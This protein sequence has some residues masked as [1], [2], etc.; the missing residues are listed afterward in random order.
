MQTSSFLKKVIDSYT[1][2]APIT[3]VVATDVATEREIADYGDLVGDLVGSVLRPALNNGQVIY[4]R[5]K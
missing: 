2:E 3:I 1:T 4:E 5:A